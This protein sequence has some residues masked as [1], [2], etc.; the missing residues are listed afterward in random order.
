MIDLLQ[1]NNEEENIKLIQKLKIYLLFFFWIF[2]SNPILA[3]EKP[4]KKS[5]FKS[6]NKSTDQLKNNPPDKLKAKISD[7]A[8][9]KPTDKINDIIYQADVIQADLDTGKAI[10]KGNVII[11][12]EGYKLTAPEAEIIKAESR[13]TAK[14]G[15]KIE[16]LMTQ[17]T[18][19][20]VEIFF[21]NNT[22][23]LKNARIESGQMLLEAKEI[24]KLDKDVFEADNSY[25]TTCVTCPPLWRFGA[26]KIKADINKY[27]DIRWANLQ[28]GKI[29]ILW[30]PRL[31]LPVNTRRKTG[32]LPPA[33][34]FS[35]SRGQ[36]GLEQGYFWAIA[37]NKDLTFTPTI[38]S[39][40]GV[41]S[42]F[43]YRHVFDSQ[44]RAEIN[45]G[46]LKDNDFETY[47][48][49]DNKE[50]TRIL[51]RWFI[52]FKNQLYLPNNFIQKS[53]IRLF[54]D[55]LYLSDFPNEV[56]GQRDANVENQISL[57]K[58]EGKNHFSSEIVYN[59]NL[60][61]EDFKSDNLNAVHRTPQL[62]YS[63]L[64]SILLKNFRFSFD[65][66][67]NKFS[68]KGLSFDNVQ[69]PTFPAT[70]LPNGLP[71][72]ILTAGNGTFDPSSGLIRSG[73]RLFVQPKIVGSFN[74]GKNF[75]L[76]PKLSFNQALYAFSPEFDSGFAA[77][78][79]NLPYSESAN[80][81][82]IE[83]E[84]EIKTKFSKVLNENWKHIIE[85]SMSYIYGDLLYETDHLFFQGP[86]GLPYYRRFQ[87]INDLDFF[88][89]NHGI[90]FDYYDR[91]ED[92]QIVKF[93]LLQ[94]LLRKDKTSD[95]SYYSQPVFFELSQNYDYLNARTA[96]PDAWS[97]LNALVKIKT[98]HIETFTQA[99]HFHK[100]KET[101][102]STRSKYIFKSGNFL[103]A[104][105]KKNNLISR[106]NEVELQ[107][108]FFGA[109]LGLKLPS[110]SLSGELLYSTYDD[111]IQQWQM[112]VGYSPP[113][114]CLDIFFN[115]Y[116]NIDRRQ[117][118]TPD[119]KF[120]ITWNFGQGNE[121]PA[122]I[123]AVF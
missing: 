87:P 31:I 72:D 2:F 30:I 36:F 9:N 44:S 35:T 88:D 120:Q 94:T 28:A 106:T 40:S 112:R 7:P 93:S 21:D 3:Q 91:I 15:V 63:R 23:I 46:Y 29:P 113:G 1:I 101:N 79:D 86:K 66:E 24:R 41:K 92:T 74:L 16:N 42:V 97:T 64:N 109:G 56:Q 84:L 17:M 100:I 18:A 73:H 55:L 118:N 89:Y 54:S 78:T 60:L 19:D 108:E 33:P 51:N 11:Y 62:R 96:N 116:D 43:N 26:R 81:S 117:A 119:I 111:E 95:V 38:Y 8:S 14:G 76:L 71:K 67:Y 49:N 103:S 59:I 77:N 48:F 34:V 4:T 5:A 13:F 110:I 99:A 69:L 61:T 80:R 20:H 82:Y 53:N 85:P 70:E 27:V 10:L 90:Q 75:I 115:V 6:V 83:S 107:Q 45:F 102:I 65:T 47:D 50:T 37:D 52:D 105:Y 98:K 57:I 122:D 114:E 123:Q 121:R 22:G 104:S 32:L 39:K 68:R 12:F 25:F 58:N